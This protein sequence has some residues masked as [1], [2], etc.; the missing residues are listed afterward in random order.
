M[1]VPID[2]DFIRLD[3][4]LKFT[5]ALPTGGQ[6]KLAIQDGLVLVNHQVCTM[7]GKK[8]RPGDCVEFGSECYEVTK[9]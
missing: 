8:L 3:Q 6:A 5:G 4:L 2:S 1:F 7:R 9:A